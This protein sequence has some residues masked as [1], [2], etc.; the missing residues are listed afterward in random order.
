VAARE[1][2]QLRAELDQVKGE[3]A[4]LKKVLVGGGAIVL[5]GKRFEVDASYSV[6]K[7][8]SRLKAL[9]ES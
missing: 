2:E 6:S 1:V 8:L 9:E 7:I 3:L 4:D 5:H